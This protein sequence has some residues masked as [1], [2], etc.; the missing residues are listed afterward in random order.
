VSEPIRYKDARGVFT[1]FGS[2]K[3][4]G[5]T[6]RPVTFDM[7]DGGSMEGATNHPD[8]SSPDAE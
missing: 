1:G 2:D 6:A 3:P 5:S 4:L 8:D 7:P